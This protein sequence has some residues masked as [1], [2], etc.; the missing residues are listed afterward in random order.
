MMMMN[1]SLSMNKAPV[2][3][4]RATQ[5]PRSL[6][7]AAAPPGGPAPEPAFPVAAPEAPARTSSGP[8]A[9][10]NYSFPSTTTPYD[11]FKFAPIREAQ[12]SLSSEHRGKFQELC[13]RAHLLF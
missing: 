4:G 2:A 7:V 12:V 1:K 6:R 13:R 5:Q 11:D 3:A 8:V 10:P 9:T